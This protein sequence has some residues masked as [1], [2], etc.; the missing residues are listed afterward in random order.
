[1]IISLI[2]IA[3]KIFF[4]MSVYAFAFQVMN[5]LPAIIFFA[6]TVKKLEINFMIN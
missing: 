4:Q 6:L 1:M 5:I 3:R 2:V